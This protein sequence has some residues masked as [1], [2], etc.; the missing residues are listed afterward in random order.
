MEQARWA[1]AQ[2]REDYQDQEGGDVEVSI[3]IEP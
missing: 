3:E 1:V 2:G